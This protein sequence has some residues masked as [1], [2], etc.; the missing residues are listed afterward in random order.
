MEDVRAHTGTLVADLVLDHA[1]SL[2]DKRQALRPLLQKL[3]QQDFAIAQVGPADL[4]RRAF[5][6]ISDVSGSVARLE[7]RLDAAE[8]IIYASE[9]AVANLHREITSYS[10]PSA[11]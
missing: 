10:A 4:T 1:D 8:R 2:K 9:F 11:P 5:V 3:R 6:A 7:E